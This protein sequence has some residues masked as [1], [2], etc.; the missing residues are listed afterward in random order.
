MEFSYNL[1]VFGLLLAGKDG[2]LRQMYR[3][4]PAKS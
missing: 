3:E 4:D 1:Y 2:V